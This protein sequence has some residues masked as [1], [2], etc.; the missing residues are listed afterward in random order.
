M[1]LV[2]KNLGS[3]QVEKLKGVGDFSQMFPFCHDD[4]QFHEVVDAM[5]SNSLDLMPVVDRFENVVG[6]IRG[7]D[8]MDSIKLK[9]R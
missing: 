1:M 9:V 7:I 2:R 5:R 6:M 4:A 8:V 3:A